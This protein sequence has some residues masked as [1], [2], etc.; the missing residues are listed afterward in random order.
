MASLGDML[1]LLVTFICLI[2]LVAKFA[3]KPVTKMMSERATKINNDLDYAEN[4]RTEAQALAEKRQ[5]ELKNSQ[6]DAVKI[7]STA[8]ENGEKQRQSIVDAANQEVTTL[9]QNAQQDIAQQRKDAL[10][11]AKDDVAE[12]SLAIASKI[13]GKELDADDQQSLID[14]YIKGLGD[15]NGTH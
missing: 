2:A 11:S 5:A 3:W 4:A 12:L 10:N 13:I 7:V 9:K 1:F 8:K 6:A 15:A 14:S